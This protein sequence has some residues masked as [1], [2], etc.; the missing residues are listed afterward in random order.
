MTPHLNKRRLF[1]AAL[2]ALVLLLAQLGL[3]FHKADL[4][5]HGA[6]A[7]EF[8]LTHADLTDAASFVSI[9]PVVIPAA[10]YRPAF[11]PAAPTSYRHPLYA[12]R[13][14]PSRYL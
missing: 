13:A 11:V 8:C 4:T 12:A 6:A 2:L 10:S 5:Q 14:P 9:Q 1:R 3:I 7:C